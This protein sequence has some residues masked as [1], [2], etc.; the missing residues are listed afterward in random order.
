MLRV[1][2][3]AVAAAYCALE[4][5]GRET[6]GGSRPA[7]GPV[8]GD[9]VTAAAAAQS[10]TPSAR[11]ERENTVIQHISRGASHRSG[12]KIFRGAE[13]GPMVQCCLVT[14]CFKT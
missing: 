1:R 4:G 9:A 3:A 14:S 12:Q 6:E 11:R 10:V 2:A 5:G 13:E 7:G 8:S